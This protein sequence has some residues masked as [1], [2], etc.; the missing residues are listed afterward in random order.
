VGGTFG[1]VEFSGLVLLTDGVSAAP[2]RLSLADLAVHLDVSRETLRL[3]IRKWPDFPILERGTHGQR[4]QFD[5]DAVAA[6]VRTRRQ[7]PRAG[8]LDLSG[9]ADGTVAQSLRDQLDVEKLELL[10]RQVERL[11][12]LEVAARRDL[13]PVAAVL[14]GL[15]AALQQFGKAMRASVAASCRDLNMPEA[16]ARAFERNLDAVLREF[17]GTL[18]AVLRGEG[19]NST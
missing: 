4:Y 12:R 17:V 6:F 16:V 15:A 7:P 8:S 10:R 2:V 11:T 9:G 14:E 3:W 19:G 1:P 18:P 5:P 13:V